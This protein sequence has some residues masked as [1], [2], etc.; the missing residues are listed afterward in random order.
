MHIRILSPM[1]R[2]SPLILGLLAPLLLSACSVRTPPGT[3]HAAPTP[4]NATA[5][6][7]YRNPFPPVEL[8]VHPLSRIT[9]DP[10]T[11]D[12]RIEAHFELLDT[13]GHTVKALGTAALELRV[14]DRGTSGTSG[15]PRQLARWTIDMSTPDENA[16]P[17]DRVTRTY[18]LTLIDLPRPLPPAETLTLS[19]RYSTTS[20]VRLHAQRRLGRER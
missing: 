19:V 1:P 12:A 7:R 8:V 2:F 14:V 11:G 16:R 5:G 17:F 13:Y 3:S 18:R 4:N 10:D 15:G 6:V 20:G 9:T